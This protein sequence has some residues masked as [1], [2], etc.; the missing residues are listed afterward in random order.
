MSS[1][2]D[3][4]LAKTVTGLS[5]V[6][7]QLDG[8]MERAEVP[9]GLAALPHDSRAGRQPQ[10]GAALEAVDAA[11]PQPVPPSLEE[12]ALRAAV[13]SA[14][15]TGRSPVLVL[16]ETSGLDGDALARAL[17]AALRY[18]VLESA[19][20]MAL[21]PAFDLLGPADAAQRG[22]VIVKRGA[23]YLAVMGN[24]FDLALRGWLELKIPQSLSW[25]L[26]APDEITAYVAKFEQDL[27]AMDV[28]AV[29]NDGEIGRAHV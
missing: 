2:R 12:G 1:V 20:L 15:A 18:P 11:Q 25:H 27:R 6:L 7:D 19:A 3:P 8:L 13:A 14:A 16:A 26:A 28:A 22:C 21:A 10:M 29:A 24:P 23:E 17:G 9:V 4:V 5:R